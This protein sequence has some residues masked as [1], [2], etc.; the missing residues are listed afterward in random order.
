LKNSLLS[1]L[2]V[3]TISSIAHAA[4]PERALTAVIL[5][6][7]TPDRAV[8]DAVSNAALPF[9]KALSMSAQRE[10]GDRPF[11]RYGIDSQCPAVTSPAQA[12]A[13]RLALLKAFGKADG[14]LELALFWQPKQE[15]KAN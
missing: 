6:L 4:E 7:N 8:F 10:G 11:E 5:R 1:L 3:L 14:Q 12:E 2:A 9:C 15:T 13:L